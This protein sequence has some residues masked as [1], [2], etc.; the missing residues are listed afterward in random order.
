M[1]NGRDI[2]KLRRWCIRRR[3]EHARFPLHWKFIEYYNYERPHMALNYSTPAEVY[4]RDAPNV[5]GYYSDRFVAIST[6]VVVFS[7]GSGVLLQY[8]TLSYGLSPR[9]VV[10]YH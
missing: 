5:L 10:G 7:C 8:L 4:F 3:G 2:V 9:L 1:K 6:F